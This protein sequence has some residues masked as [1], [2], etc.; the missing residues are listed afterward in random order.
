M[1][2]AAA[3]C[4]PGTEYLTDPRDRALLG[5]TPTLMA[6]RFGRLPPPLEGQHRFVAG[7][8]GLYLQAR[9]RALDVALR[10]AETPFPLPYGPVQEGVLLRHG[11]IGQDLLLEAE[12]RARAAAPREW[13]GVVVLDPGG[14]YRLIEPPTL[15]SRADSVRYR[16][17]GFDPDAL[18]VDLHSH[19]DGAAYFSTTDDASDR[20]GGIYLAAVIGGCRDSRPTWAWRLVVNGLFFPLDASVAAM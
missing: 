1:S 13:A 12:A 15:W 11:A 17:E 5:A 4:P 10:V 19:G 2:A 16:V 6:P 7:E 14:A 9:S 3:G 20:E 18:G 8:G